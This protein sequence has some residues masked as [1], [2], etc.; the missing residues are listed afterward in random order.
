MLCQEEQL[1]IKA[2]PL[3][4]LVAV[5]HLCRLPREKLHTHHQEWRKWLHIEQMWLSIFSSPL[6]NPLQVCRRHEWPEQ[7]S[8]I[9]AVLRALSRPASK[10]EVTSQLVSH[11]EAALRVSGASPGNQQH[12]QV[13]AVHQEVAVP[14]ALGHGL[15]F[16]MGP[17]SN[18]HSQ[19][20]LHRHLPHLSYAFLHPCASC[21]L[22]RGCEPYA[23]KHIKHSEKKGY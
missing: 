2:P 22:L 9:L 4:P 12:H 6:L 15:C 23:F 3:Q 8:P 10:H 14:A 1:H 13:E 18:S 19:A 7:H 17:G 16:Q 11:L 5:Q 20:L 21:M